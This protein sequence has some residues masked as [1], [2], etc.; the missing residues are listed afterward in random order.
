MSVTLLSLAIGLTMMSGYSARLERGV[1]RAAH[2]R[3]RLA[4]LRRA[5]LALR[6]LKVRGGAEVVLRGGVYSATGGAVPLE[7]TA[8]D[9]G[10]TS[11][12]P[13]V[14]RAYE[15]EAVTIS[16]GP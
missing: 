13:V 7:L 8:E 9:S 1:A 16:G 14:W 3:H 15:G 5:Q 4:S 10:S 2:V 12:G 11:A 6:Q